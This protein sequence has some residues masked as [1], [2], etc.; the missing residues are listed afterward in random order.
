MFRVLGKLK[1]FLVS[2]LALALVL[3]IKLVLDLGSG[4]LSIFFILVLL[5][6][7]RSKLKLYIARGS[8]VL[9]V[10]PWSLVEFLDP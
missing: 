1:S 8:V 10:Y 9:R 5:I 4:S 3:G 6:F 2:Y 7:L